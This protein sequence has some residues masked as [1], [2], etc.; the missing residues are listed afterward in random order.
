MYCK[1]IVNKKLLP[2]EKLFHSGVKTL[3]D[4]EL[5]AIIIGSGIK[6]LN[7][8]ELSKRIVSKLDT[9]KNELRF[10]DIKK[11]PGLGK[12][13]A[14]LILAANEFFRRRI[15]PEGI[16]ITCPENVLPLIS[17]LNTKQKEHF[18]LITLNGA[19]EV[20]NTHIITIG[21]INRTQIHPR[22]VFF[23]AIKDRAVS[24]IIAHNHPSGSLKPSK[25]DIKI[26][27]VLN[28]TGEIVGIN[29]LD[30]IIFSK[31]GYFSLMEN[32][33]M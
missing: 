7:V 19:S 32:S 29:L 16:K 21:L 6:G 23:E 17:Y 20:I 5:M 26:T 25:E 33:L 12:A 28:E 22:E 3:N 27:N 31:T 24:I 9:Y 1:K 13:K 2:R 14:A 30:H 11:V 15:K 8:F 4:E 18:I 10:N